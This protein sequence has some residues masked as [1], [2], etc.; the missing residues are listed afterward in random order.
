MSLLIRNKLPSAIPCNNIIAC[1]YHVRV[2]TTKLIKYLKR[3]YTD[4]K[5]KLVF[6]M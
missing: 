2:A 1:S 6:G 3:N 4:L 5:F